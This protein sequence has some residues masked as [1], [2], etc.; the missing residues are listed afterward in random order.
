MNGLDNWS[1]QYSQQY[2]PTFIDLHAACQA[3][4]K[5]RLQF[6]SS[7]SLC[8]SPGGNWNFSSPHLWPECAENTRAKA[9]HWQY[10]G[11]LFRWYPVLLK[12]CF[13]DAANCGLDFKLF[14]PTGCPGPGAPHQV[15]LELAG[16]AGCRFW[17]GRQ[18]KW[19]S[20]CFDI[21]P[22]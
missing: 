15:S 2:F 4:A 16:S 8:T 7:C 12:V 9:A 22:S 21:G 20:N 11:S 1:R 6:R 14:S 17:S 13:E 18:K 19:I 10:F 3:T 5:H